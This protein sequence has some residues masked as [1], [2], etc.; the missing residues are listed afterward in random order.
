MSSPQITR[1][2]GFSAAMHAPR[3]SDVDPCA[4]RVAVARRFVPHP[5]WT[6]ASP[7]NERDSLRELADA[8]YVTDDGK[9]TTDPAKSTKG[10]SGRPLDNPARNVWITETALATALNVSYTGTQLSLLSLVI[11][12]RVPAR[13][14]RFH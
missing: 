7:A 9:R 3:S 8:G 10:P 4:R 5:A 14:Y 13:G 1:M 6:I 2:F 11:G 12:V